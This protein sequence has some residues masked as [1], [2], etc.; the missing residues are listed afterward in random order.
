[1]KTQI[2]NAKVIL[3][4]HDELIIECKKEDK[5]I[6]KTILQNCMLIQKNALICKWLGG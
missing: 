1:M 6:V 3:Q 4:V 2:I 5:G